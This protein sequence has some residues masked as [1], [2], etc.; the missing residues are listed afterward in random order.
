VR[1]S[2]RSALTLLGLLSLIRSS[3]YV[4]DLTNGSGLIR[5]AA[6]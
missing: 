6:F 4:V 1:M 5:T 2:G 3:S